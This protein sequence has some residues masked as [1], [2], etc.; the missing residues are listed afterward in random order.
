MEALGITPSQDFLQ[1]CWN[2]VRGTSSKV[3][4][5]LG[6]VLG[7]HVLREPV[8]ELLAG[9]LRHIEEPYADAALV[10]SPGEFCLGLHRTG[11]SGQSEDDGGHAALWNLAADL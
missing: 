2:A 10:V 9:A 8:F 5:G 6:Q 7:G 3:N 11:H 1:G 4:T